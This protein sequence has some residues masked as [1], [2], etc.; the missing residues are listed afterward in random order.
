MK[1]Y[2]F[3]GFLALSIFN[4][5]FLKKGGLLSEASS[6]IIKSIE[7]DVSISLYFSRSVLV[8]EDSGQD[9]N[10]FVERIKSLLKKISGINKKIRFNYHEPKPY[11]ELYIKALSQGL[12]TLNLN[13]GAGL[14]LGIVI[15]SSNGSKSIIDFS[16]LGDERNLLRNIIKNIILVTKKRAGLYL[17]SGINLYNSKSFKKTILYKNLSAWFDINLIKG[18]EKD[19]NTNLPILLIN[20]VNISNN[21]LRFIKK[22][23]VRVIVVWDPYYLGGESG[24]DPKLS[25]LFKQNGIFLIKDEVILD[26]SLSS[27]ASTKLSSLKKRIPFFITCEKKCLQN[28]DVKSFDRLDFVI[29]GAVESSVGESIF[30]TSSNSMVLKKEVIKNLNIYSDF[31][32]RLKPLNRSYSIVSHVNRF[33]IFSDID[34]LS[35]NYLGISDQNT[36]YMENDNLYFFISTINKRIFGLEDPF[37]LASPLKK[38][39]KFSA[40]D[41]FIEKTNLYTQPMLNELNSEVEKAQLRIAKKE[42]ELLLLSSDNNKNFINNLNLLKKQLQLIYQKIRLI[43]HSN[44][45]EFKK[46]K[47]KFLRLNYLILFIMFLSSLFVRKKLNKDVHQNEITK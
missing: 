10:F 40:F 18:D 37:S 23:N 25:L 4:I 22:G 3:I 15:S 1:K 26:P 31:S 24:I 47:T 11:S 2:L 46:Y 36:F 21:M 13:D 19:L 43:E 38:T 12:K 41:E 8:E 17:Y 35:D 20:P 30:S 34:F 32:K 6:L 33:L 29:S 28:N 44:V 14:L 39:V 5:F 45:H 9:F 27:V 42:G 16:E 7:T